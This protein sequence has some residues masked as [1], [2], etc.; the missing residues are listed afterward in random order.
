MCQ[1]NSFKKIKGLNRIKHQTILKNLTHLKNCGDA[2]KF[3]T[4]FSFLITWYEVQFKTKLVYL[5]N[6][7][8]IFI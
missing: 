7:S 8:T 6:V 1:K 2:H 3:E 4:K 5:N